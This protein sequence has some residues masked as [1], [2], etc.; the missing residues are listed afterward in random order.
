MSEWQDIKDAP[1]DG[2]P[3]LLYANVRGWESYEKARCVG[4][5]DGRNWSAYGPAFGEPGPQ[6]IRSALC[7]QRI[8][9]CQP[10]HWMPLPSPPETQ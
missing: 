4:W 10:T 5:F 8:T 9:E 6:K 2:T 7:P 3:L 1:K